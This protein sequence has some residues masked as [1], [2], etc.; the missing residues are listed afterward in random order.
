MYICYATPPRCMLVC[1]YAMLL[2]LDVCM[3]VCHATPPRRMYVCLYAM[4]LLLDIC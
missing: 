1:L 2:L 3:F 4:L